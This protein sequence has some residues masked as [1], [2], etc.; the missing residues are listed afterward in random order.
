VDEA[1]AGGPGGL[2]KSG[3]LG[4]KNGRVPPHPIHQRQVVRSH[5]PFALH[6]IGSNAKPPHH[7][8]LLTCRRLAGA[9]HL[10]AAACQER[11]LVG[12]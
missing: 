9:G 7:A 11:I 10:D 4:A 8:V 12:H 6:A 5:S 1:A 3:S 2:D